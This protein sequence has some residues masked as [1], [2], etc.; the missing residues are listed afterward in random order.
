M[1]I[2]NSS[3]DSEE[4]FLAGPRAEEYFFGDSDSNIGLKLQVFVWEAFHT[5]SP[6]H[7]HHRLRMIRNFV[8]TSPSVSVASRQELTHK[9]LCSWTTTMKATSGSARCETGT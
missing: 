5:I 6:S 3:F 1:T 9:G 8:Y 4:S 7:K 2:K